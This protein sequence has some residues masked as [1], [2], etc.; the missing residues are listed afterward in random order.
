[1][2]PAL[3]KGKLKALTADRRLHQTVSK[4]RAF[5]REIKREMKRRPG[6]AQHG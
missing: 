1:M 2:K 6:S 3:L 5:R 4:E